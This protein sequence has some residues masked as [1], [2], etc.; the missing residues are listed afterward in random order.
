[1]KRLIAVFLIAILISGCDRWTNSVSPVPQSSNAPALVPQPLKVLASEPKFSNIQET[2][3]R[4][5]SINEKNNLQTN[6][7]VSK[8]TALE[9]LKSWIFRHPFTILS[10][11]SITLLSAF[12]IDLFCKLYNVYKDDKHQLYKIPPVQHTMQMIA[13][14]WLFSYCRHGDNSRL[15]ERYRSYIK[16]LIDLRDANIYKEENEVL[17]LNK[18]INHPLHS[19]EEMISLCYKKVNKFIL[20]EDYKDMSDTARFMTYRQ[21]LFSLRDSCLYTQE[22]ELQKLD[23]EL[24]KINNYIDEKDPIQPAFLQNLRGWFSS[25]QAFINYYYNQMEKSYPCETEQFHRY[26]NFLYSLLKFSSFLSLTENDIKIIDYEIGQNNKGLDRDIPRIP[27]F[28]LPSNQPLFSPFPPPAQSANQFP[29]IPL[30]APNFP[31]FSQI[32]NFPFLT[33]RQFSS[34]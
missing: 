33:F 32:P 29:Q 1:M 19:V 7:E 20:R 28:K 18:R 25:I 21:M 16:S 6:I 9:K 8:Q 26:N 4:Q 17:A 5:V 14:K 27:I 15:G 12:F 2:S 31:N 23:A 34:Q 11:V 24:S 22:D 10:V 30:S 3:K 13:D